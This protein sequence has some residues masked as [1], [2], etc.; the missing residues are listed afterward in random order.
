M[1]SPRARTYACKYL[2]LPGLTRQSI[3]LRKKRFAKWMDGRVKPGHDETS[4][5]QLLEI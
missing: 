1:H 3:Y 4:E 5:A 2:S